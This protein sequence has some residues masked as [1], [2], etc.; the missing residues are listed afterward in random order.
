MAYID[1]KDLK[2]RDWKKFIGGLVIGGFISG[3]TMWII[4]LNYIANL[5]GL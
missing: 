4:M 1:E 2:G 5:L 3:L